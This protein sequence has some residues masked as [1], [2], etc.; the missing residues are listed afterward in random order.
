MEG[1][2]GE[3]GGGGGLLAWPAA[4]QGSKWLPL[5]ILRATY[6]STSLY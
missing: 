5:F 2:G 1:V 3:A 6:S 4:A